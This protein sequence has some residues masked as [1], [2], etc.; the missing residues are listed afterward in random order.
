MFD[1]TPIFSSVL[2]SISIM[3]ITSDPLGHATVAYREVKRVCDFL[4]MV[5]LP[6]AANITVQ[7]NPIGRAFSRLC[8][9][10]FIPFVGELEK[11]L[12]IQG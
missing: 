6:S 12:V 10:S 1:A 4:F 7:N 9:S 5:R 8:I 3:I 2:E 11:A